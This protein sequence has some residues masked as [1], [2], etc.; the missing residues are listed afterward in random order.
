MG[1]IERINVIENS[2]KQYVNYKNLIVVIKSCYCKLFLSNQLHLLVTGKGLGD[3]IQSLLKL[4]V[5]KIDFDITQDEEKY[6]KSNIH[7]HVGQY[8]SFF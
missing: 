5:I 2:E 6:F 8:E 7:T 4:L 1:V 3:R